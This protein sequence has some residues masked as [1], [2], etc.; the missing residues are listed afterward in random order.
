MKRLHVHPAFLRNSHK[1]CFA[2]HPIIIPGTNIPFL[3]IFV[4]YALY[5]ML[6]S[7]TK[8]QYTH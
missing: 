5:E 7:D 4:S 8:T 3:F 2:I 6:V 1:G